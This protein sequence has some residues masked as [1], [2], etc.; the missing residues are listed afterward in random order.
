M[1]VA[2]GVERLL[3]AFR[4]KVW[5]TPE[6]DKC[7]LTLQKRFKS[8]PS[9]NSV[10]IRLPTAGAIPSMMTASSSITDKSLDG[11]EFYNSTNVVKEKLKNFHYAGP[12]KRFA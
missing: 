1:P 5:E 11:R 6:P 3:R 9:T 2:I 12:C 10:S 7:P 4:A 8:S